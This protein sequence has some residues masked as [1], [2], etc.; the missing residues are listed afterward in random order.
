MLGRRKHT[1]ESVEAMLVDRGATVQQARELV[2]TLG[3]RL[4]AKEMHVWL[5]DDRRSHGIPDED[6]EL[7]A[8]WEAMGLVLPA[9]HWTPVNAI[10]A[11]K[12]D[13]VLAEA[14]RFVSP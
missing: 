2:E 11:G 8:E 4:S 9:M 5:A 14:R 10:G 7:K 6:P 13:L 12:T 3:R 1:E